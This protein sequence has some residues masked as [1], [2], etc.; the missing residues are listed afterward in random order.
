[1]ETKE[2]IITGKQYIGKDEIYVRDFYMCPNCK[3]IYITDDDNYCSN[4]G[5]KIVFKLEKT[6]PFNK[7]EFHTFKQWINYYNN[8]SYQETITKCRSNEIFKE[9][10]SNSDLLGKYDFFNIIE[11][12][13]CNSIV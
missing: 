13:A 5:S 7:E 4:C 8:T 9:K 6:E 11:E 1:M 10:E 2:V 12:V 3:Y